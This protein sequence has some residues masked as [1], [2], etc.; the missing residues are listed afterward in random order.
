MILDGGVELLLCSVDIDSELYCGE[1]SDVV[2]EDAEIWYTPMQHEEEL[3]CD[4]IADGATV[5]K[6]GPL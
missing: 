3:Y 6:R 4:V 5:Q 1:C 2:A